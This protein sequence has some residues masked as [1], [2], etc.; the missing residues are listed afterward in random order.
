MSRGPV[1]YMQ[2]TRDYYR[3]QGFERD[4]VWAHNED[5]PFSPL[6]RP[7]SSCVVTVVTTAVPNPGAAVKS[8]REAVSERFEETPAHFGTGDLAWDKDSTH[9][10]DRGSYFPLEPLERL[11]TEGYIGHLAPRFHFVPT[12]YSQ[13]LTLTKDAPAI[14]AACREDEVDVATLVPL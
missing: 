10:N 14:A 13:R 3:A 7:L 6:P 11:E 9:T 2:R 1:N 5:I 4:Y 12:E 8:L